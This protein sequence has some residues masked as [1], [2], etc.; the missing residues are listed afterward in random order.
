MK[1]L[2]LVLE[3]LTRLLDF[4]TQKRVER[5]S[6]KAKDD[7]AA[8]FNEHFD[9]GVQPPTTEESPSPH[10]TNSDSHKHE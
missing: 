1:W 3:L 6:Q 8:W 7:P 10:E 4:I 5:E 2:G 9:G